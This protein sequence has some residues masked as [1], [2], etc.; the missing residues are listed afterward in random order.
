M[1][2]RRRQPTEAP[3]LTLADVGPSINVDFIAEMARDGHVFDEVVLGVDTFPADFKEKLSPEMLAIL[4]G[5]IAVF[6]TI[7]DQ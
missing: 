2:W 3:T 5:P 6:R 1:F 4:S 7:E